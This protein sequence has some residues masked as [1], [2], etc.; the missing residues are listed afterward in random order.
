MSVDES[1]ASG[2]GDS[3]GSAVNACCWVDVLPRYTDIDEY[4]G[5]MFKITPFYYHFLA[6]IKTRLSNI[7]RFEDALVF[8]FEEGD[9]AIATCDEVRHNPGLQT[10]IRQ[11][12]IEIS[13]MIHDLLDQPI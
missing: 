4:M 2:V 3:C 13:N 12:K 8:H 9:V 11:A 6:N 10:A 5:R 7:L 1:R